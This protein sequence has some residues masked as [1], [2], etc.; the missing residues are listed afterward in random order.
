VEIYDI[1]MLVVLVGAALFGAIKGFAWQLASIASIVVSYIVAY[2]FREPFSQSIQAE[3]PWNRFLAM[4]ILYVGTS[5]VI[6]VAFRMISGTID[7]LK[8]REFD[9]HVGAI[10]GLAKGALF[11]T[12]ITLFAVTLLGESLRA[13]IVASK[14]GRYIAQ[15]LDQSESVIPPEIHEVVRPYLD[16]F[17]ERFNGSEQDAGQDMSPGGVLPWIADRVLNDPSSSQQD[18]LPESFWNTASR[19]QNLSQNAAP[20]WAAGSAPANDYTGPATQTYGQPSY[21]QPAYGQPSYGGDSGYGQ[22]GNVPP[23]Y[24]QPAYNQPGYGQPSS[25][26][27]P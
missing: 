22:P 7:R 10:F 12:L 4:L 20:P 17:D 23:S 25:Y 13:K 14:S 9:R 15:V 27:R 11:C 6:W 2:H 8:L 1:L 21:D 16:R 5:L 18:R 26:R 19:N 3:P 24:G